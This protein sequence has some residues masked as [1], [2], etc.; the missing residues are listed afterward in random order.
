MVVRL[1]QGGSTDE[2][3]VLLARARKIRVS[4]DP[5][6]IKPRITLRWLDIVRFSCEAEDPPQSES[7]RGGSH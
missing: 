2:D 4:V 3:L 5:S 7:S 1:I 6:T